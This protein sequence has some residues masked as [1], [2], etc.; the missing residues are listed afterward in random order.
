MHPHRCRHGRVGLRALR[1]PVS[2]CRSAQGAG[3]P[4]R[5]VEGVRRPS[6]RAGGL[7]V[8]PSRAGGMRCVT[9]G[10][11]PAPQGRARTDCARRPGLVRLPAVPKDFARRPQGPLGAVDSTLGVD[12]TVRRRRAHPGAIVAL[13]SAAAQLSVACWHYLSCPPLYMH[14]G[15]HVCRRN[16]TRVRALH[17]TPPIHRTSFQAPQFHRAAHQ[18]Q[19]PTPLASAQR[20]RASAADA[21]LLALMHKTCMHRI[22]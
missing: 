3:M 11:S 1:A 18:S 5:P 9:A 22:R 17:G 2:R 12:G 13:P 21:R 15:T 16:Y 10:R 14:T 7:G 4:C 6:H 20:A 8:P 19:V